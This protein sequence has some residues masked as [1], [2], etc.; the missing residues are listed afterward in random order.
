M[1]HPS[2]TVLIII[3]KP[4]GRISFEIALR[5]A[6]CSLSSILLD[7]PVSC[8]P[9]MRTI[10]LPARDPRGYAG[11]FALPG[12]FY[13]LHEHFDA[14]RHRCHG[15]RRDRGSRS[16]RLRGSER[17]VHAGST[18][19]T[20]PCIFRRSLVFQHPFDE[21]VVKFSP[22]VEDR[23]PDLFRIDKV[24]NYFFAGTADVIVHTSSHQM[25]GLTVPEAAS[26]VPTHSRDDIEILPSFAYALVPEALRGCLRRS[27]RDPYGEEHGTALKVSPYSMPLFSASFQGRSGHVAV[28]SRRR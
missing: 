15:R 11:A 21:E 12:I 22:L 9:G 19:S 6:L 16:F 26:H 14:R 10:Y 27:V 3:P 4:S 7:T 18:L 13:D 17:R 25:R 24:Y 28:R 8:P 20:W 5:R 1:S 23:D 2:A